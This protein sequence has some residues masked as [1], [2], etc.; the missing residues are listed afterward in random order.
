MIIRR[1]EWSA[2][3][4]YVDACTMWH[5]NDSAHPVNPEDIRIQIYARTPGPVMQWRIY[6]KIPDSSQVSEQTHP[7]VSV[8]QADINK[9]AFAKPAKGLR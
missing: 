1:L 2:I 6:A 4:G 3:L 5:A 9:P 8:V 7:E